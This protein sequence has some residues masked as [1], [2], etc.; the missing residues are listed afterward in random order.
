LGKTLETMARFH[1]PKGFEKMEAFSRKIPSKKPL[2]SVS[3]VEKL[4]TTR[5][6]DQHYDNQL[7][8]WLMMPRSMYGKRI[9]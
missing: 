4:D 1:D 8:H 7:L 3:T 5:I 9:Q 6:D 2:R